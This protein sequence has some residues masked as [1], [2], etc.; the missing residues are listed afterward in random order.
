[1]LSASSLLAERDPYRTRVALLEE[2]RLTELFVERNDE[3]GVVGDV[4]KARVNRVL[5][6]MQAAFL[7]IGLGRDA[8]LHVDDLRERFQELEDVEPEAEEEDETAAVASSIEELLRPGVEVLVQVVKDPVSSKG[9]R[10]T[11]HVTLPG[12]FLVV[13]PLGA[14]LGVSR[15]IE[16]PGERSRLREL[17]AGL[18]PVGW[19]VRTAGE[20]QDRSTLEADARSLLARWERI[21]A[22]A[23]ATTA[24]GRVHRELGVALRVVRDRFGPEFE[25]LW[26]E[27]DDLHEEILAFLE[28]S[29]PSLAGLVRRHRRDRSLF[30]TFGVEEAIEEALHPRVWLESGGYLVIQPTEA[31]VAI[32]VNTGRFVGSEDLERTI[33]ATNL[34]AVREIVRQIRLRNLGGI[35]ILDLIDMTDPAHRD[36]VFAALTAELRRDRA[37]SRV[38][39]ISEFGLV[40]ITRKRSRP[41]LERS[42]TVAC[43]YCD[44]QGRIRSLGTIVFSLRRELLGRGTPAGARELLLR[45][46]PDV[47]GAL[48]GESKAVLQELE[49]RL[50]ARLLIR[51]DPGLHHERF[52][53]LEVR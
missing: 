26:V 44:G 1:M 53:I 46:H 9:A 11:T 36:Q 47:G 14:H 41:S 27:G 37:R 40:E 8:F 33:L 38:L 25:A 7:D 12:R 30:E 10:V 24:P 42:L 34:E 28:E 4:Y 3:R 13:A 23:E 18:P 50:G 39:G 35:L 20:G 17:V 19:I 31:L 6:G 51:T 49:Q 16:D 22:S 45:V 48:Q 52:E 29:E 32:D 21:R 15:R 43:P 5:P 2:G